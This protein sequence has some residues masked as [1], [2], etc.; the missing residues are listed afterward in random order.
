MPA[1]RVE[2]Q[3]IT[4]LFRT[5]NADTADAACVA[6]EEHVYDEVVEVDRATWTAI[7]VEPQ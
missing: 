7:G 1:Y 3:A 4:T 2:L 5:V 6:A